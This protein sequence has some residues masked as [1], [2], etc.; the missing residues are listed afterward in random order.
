MELKVNKQLLLEGVFTSGKKVNH[1]GKFIP[2]T[3]DRKKHLSAVSAHGKDK[4]ERNVTAK[5]AKDI[6]SSPRVQSA[7]KRINE[8]KAHGMKPRSADKDTSTLAHNLVAGGILKQA[9]KRSKSL[10]GIVKDATDTSNRIKTK[11][12]TIGD[13]NLMDKKLSGKDIKSV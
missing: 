6:R 4:A 1:P 12:H 3:A 5:Q 11:K 8:A 13:D 9:H 2:G 10:E 7:K